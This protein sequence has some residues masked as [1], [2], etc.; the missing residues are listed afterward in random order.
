MSNLES[1]PHTGEMGKKLQRTGSLE[2][3]Y[4]APDCKTRLKEKLLQCLCTRNTFPS[5]AYQLG[6]LYTKPF[7]HKALWSGLKCCNS[8]L[9]K[10][11]SM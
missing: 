7:L 10:I 1:A 9:G 5:C 2:P 3:F 8:F 11:W 6:W 4:K